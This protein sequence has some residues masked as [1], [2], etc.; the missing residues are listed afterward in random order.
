V[1]PEHCRCVEELV[2]SGSKKTEKQQL[3]A[4]QLY[5]GPASGA[6]RGVWAGEKLRGLNEGRL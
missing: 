2:G 4:V 3:L 1:G 5:I 6:T